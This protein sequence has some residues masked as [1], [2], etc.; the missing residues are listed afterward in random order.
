[1]CHEEEENAQRLSETDD[2]SQMFVTQNSQVFP[3]PPQ[4]PGGGLEN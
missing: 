1:M 4:T 2:D 3:A